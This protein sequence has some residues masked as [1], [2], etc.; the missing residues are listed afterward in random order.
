MVSLA[1][2]SLLYEWKRFLAAVLAIAFSGLLVLVQLALLLG[3]FGTSSTYVDYSPAQ[4]WVGYPG[5]P[6]VD[7]GRAIDANAEVHIRM[8]S[9]VDRIEKL[10]FVVAYWRIPSVDGLTNRGSVQSFVLGVDTHSD[11][12]A[13]SKVLPPE[14]RRRLDWPMSV[15]IDAADRE[16][17]GADV[18]KVVELGGKRVTVVGTVNGMRAIAGSNVVASLD[19]ARA[20]EGIGNKGTDSVTYL[21]LTLK[22]P[23][24]AEQTRADLQPQGPRKP[25]SV[26]VADSFSAQSQLY[27]LTASGAGAGFLFSSIL[28]LIVGIVITSQVLTGA[29]LASIREYA[30]LRALGVPVKRLAGVVIEQ[31]SWVGVAGL[32][33]GAVCVGLIGWVAHSNYVAIR[34]PWWSVLSTMILVM[35]IAIASGLLA[36]R[37]LFRADPAAML[38]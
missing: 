28:G 13:L 36:L 1:K 34:F 14:L 9:N 29:I 15:V 32:I 6:S 11:G 18:G 30:V 16:K 2:Q 31:A 5:T 7:L 27:W 38:R 23:A 3:M 25:Y 12:L 19:T 33:V 22:N 26:W 20:I 10:L 37:G 17:L 4:L 21:L 24:L 8:H 35:V